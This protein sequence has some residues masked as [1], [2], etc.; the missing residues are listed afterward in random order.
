MKT[1][2]EMVSYLTN[3]HYWIDKSIN[4]QYRLFKGNAGDQINSELVYEDPASEDLEDYESAV[5]I[6]YNHLTNEWE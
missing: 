2:Q 4:G 5:Y 3:N 1:T 6:F